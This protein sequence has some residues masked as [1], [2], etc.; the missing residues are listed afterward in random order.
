MNIYICLICTVVTGSD[1]NSSWMS[2]KKK[3]STHMA[4]SSASALLR[5]QQSVVTLPEK[6]LLCIILFHNYSTIKPTFT[7]QV[8]HHY[9]TIKTPLWHLHESAIIPTLYHK[10]T[11]DQYTTIIAPLYGKHYYTNIRPQV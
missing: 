4:P 11:T 3:G 2:I 9:E 10:C 6:G 7:P 8:Y 5:S 1:L